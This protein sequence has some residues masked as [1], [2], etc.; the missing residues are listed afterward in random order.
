MTP[1]PRDLTST[2][3]ATWEGIGRQGEKGKGEGMRLLRLEVTAIGVGDLDE[4]DE[5]MHPAVE[6]VVDEV[7]DREA[8]D[9]RLKGLHPR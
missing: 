2:A 5:T 7:V 3:V 8:V 6:S 9:Q 1:R 4:F